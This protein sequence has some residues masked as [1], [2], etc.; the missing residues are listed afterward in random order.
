MS[1]K[2]GKWQLRTLHDALAGEF[3]VGIHVAPALSAK[4][5]DRQYLTSRLF[6]LAAT[7][8]LFGVGVG[9]NQRRQVSQQQLVGDQLAGQLWPRLAGQV[10]QIAVNITAADLAVEVF[11]SEGR[12]TRLMQLGNQVPIG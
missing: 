9:T 7:G 5:F 3:N 6:A 4:L 1:V 8:F 12:T 11:I 2:V 10:L